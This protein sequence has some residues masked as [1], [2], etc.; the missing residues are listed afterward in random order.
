MHIDIQ[1]PGLPKFAERVIIK[2]SSPYALQ[3]SRLRDEARDSRV[4]IAFSRESSSD[5][6]V[7]RRMRHVSTYDRTIQV[8]AIRLT[9]HND[10]GVTRIYNEFFFH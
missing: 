8:Q 3:T 2:S 4:E 5:L 10:G 6:C 7:V 9:L 1:S